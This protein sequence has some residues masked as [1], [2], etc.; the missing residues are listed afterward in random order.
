MTLQKHGLEVFWFCIVMTALLCR[1]TNAQTFTGAVS[2]RIL[3][4]QLNGIPNAKVILRSHSQGFE[5][6]TVTTLRGEYNFQL[7]PPGSFTVA[8]EVSGFAVA[9]IE[10]DVVVAT[11][12]RADLTLRVRPLQQSV[13]VF[14]ESGI[15]V[16]TESAGLGRTISPS[17]LSELPSINRSPYDFIAIIP[18]A[19]PSNDQLGVGFVIDGARSQSANYLLDGGENN[20]A[21][22]SAPALDVPLDSIEEFGVQTNQFSAEYGRNSGFIANIVTKSGGNKVH[23]SFYDYVRNSALAA[24]TFDNNAHHLVRPEFNRNQFGL[25]LGG[26]IH[27]NKVFFFVSAE[28]ILVRSSGPNLYFVPTPALLAI[29]SPGVQSIFERYPLPASLSR[30]DVLSRKICPFGIDCSLGT[31]YV[32]VPA[33]AL[34]TRVGPQD[35]GAGVPQD[36]VLATGRVDWIANAKTQVFIR[37]AV[38]SKDEFPAVVQPYSKSLDV[39]FFSRDQN[40]TANLIHTWTANVLTE[41]RLV[42]SRVFGDPDRFGG[43]NPVVPNPP[44]PS[45]SIQNEPNVTL[46]SGAEASGGPANIYQ[47]FQTV[48]WHREHHTIRIG[49]QFVQ[50][51]DNRR[52]G[53]AETANAKFASTQDFVDGNLNSYGLALDPQ[54]HFPGESVEPPFG[55]PN[56]TRHFRYNEPAVFVEDT[57][58]VVPRVTVTAGLRWEYFGVLHGPGAERALDSN[59]YPAASGNYLA[60]I[61]NGRFFRTIDVSGSLHNHFYAPYF[62]N[63]APRFGAAYDICGDGKTRASRW[64]WTIQ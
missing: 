31:G 59:F 8:A 41:S 34:A 25:T 17:Q 52:Y 23:G 40:V 26:Y 2:G 63:F 18:G 43:S 39:P 44:S 12:T 37:Y 58:K 27:P 24:N 10:V 4:S 49:G 46:P 55:P 61:A 13:E 28:P 16:Q 56:F 6:R 45:F 22:M 29:S 3:D 15:A 5:R 38:D 21:F 32:T 57:W 53:I 54:Q 20:D 7:L 9:T 1:S 48:T 14:G 51:R 19:A 42:Y 11:S 36:T 35:A 64:C 33:F 30:T 60:Q 62:K 47:F 50:L